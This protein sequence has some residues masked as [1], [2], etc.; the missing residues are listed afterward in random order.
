M[1]GVPSYF[2]KVRSRASERWDLLE[3]DP[4][5]A[6]PWHQLFMQVQSPRHVVSELLQ[7]ADD[8][9]ATKASVG[10]NGNDFIF[11][12]NGE[13]FTEEHFASLCRFGYSNKR[14]LHT[15]GFRGVGFKSTFSIGDIISLK[16][17]SLSVKFYRERFTEPVWQN[18][19]E[20]LENNTK[21]RVAI[22]DKLRLRELEKNLEDWTN[23]PA[24]LL[25]F[26]SIRSLSIH[27]KEIQ[28][29][30]ESEGPIPDS[31][32]M[33]LST[34]PDQK[35]LMIQSKPEAFPGDALAEI[36]QERM[37]AIDEE[38]PFPPC[39]ID[40]VL[41]YEG[42]LFVILPTG[43]K[44]DLPFAINAPFIQDPA[45]LKIKDPEIS[46]T[47]RWLLERA[48]TLSSKVMLEWLN[49]TD[50]DVKNRCDAYALLPDLIS[51]DRSIEDGCG[52]I[53][54]DACKNSLMKQ[55]YLLTEKGT[56][57]RGSCC[58]AIPRDLFDIWSPDQL[59][60][61][62]SENGLNLLARYI[63]PKHRCKLINW[64]CCDEIDKEFVLDSLCLKQLPKP[65]TWAQLLRL[66]G[67]V[68]DDIT[69]YRYYRNRNR[70]HIL[71]VHGKDVLFS[72]AEV[73]RLGEK[74]LLQSKE[75]WQF[76]S[77]YLLVLN[78]NW[79]R[80]L[81]E[82]RRR[83]E[84]ETI[85][86]LE[87]QVKASYKILE[88]LNLDQSS[89][90]SHVINQVTD[91]FFQK[92]NCDFKSCIRLAQLAA[93]LGASVSEKF[94]FITQDGN[95]KP[96]SEI[97]VY[98][99][100]NDLDLFVPI[101]WYNEH[102]LHKDYSDPLSCTKDEWW[103][104]VKS[105]RSRL[106]SFVPLI[107]TERRV[108]WRNRIFEFLQERGFNGEP[109]FPYSR[110]NFTIQDWDFDKDLWQVWQLS[111][112]N[113]TEI[114]G[115]LFTRILAQSKEYWAKSLY[116]K[117]FQN[118]KKY[119]Q[120]VTNEKLPASWIIKFRALPC[121]KDTRGYYH[122]PADL[123]LRTPDTESLLDVEPFVRAEDDNE[124]TRPLIIEVGVRDTP[125][126][127]DRLID[128]IRA[129]AISENPPIYEVEKWCSRLDH[130]SNQCNTDEFQQIKDAFT[131]HK[132]ILTAD[133]EWALPLEVF[134]IANEDDAPGAAVVHPRIQNLSLWHKI[135]VAELPTAE[136]SLKWLANIESKKKL[137]KDELR[138]V[139]TL[140]PRYADRVWLE[141]KHWLNLEGEWVPVDQL[142]YKLTM[143]TLTP[144]GNLFQHV[145][146]RTADLQK[147]NADRCRQYPFVG[148]PT[149]AD[150]IE[151]R[152]EN[153]IVNSKKSLPKPW[154]SALG[155]GFTRIVE[156]DE[157]ESSQICELGHRLA[158]TKWYF[159]DTLE[160]TPFINGTPSGTP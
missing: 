2:E 143:Q 136:L 100:Q 110:D 91:S 139:R 116:A 101:Q 1:T 159:V 31:N 125:T 36:K 26:R 119:K 107:Q 97:I 130:I 34:N 151:E 21:I 121:L 76:L 47:N 99:V 123:L 89:D 22:H 42:R 28:W 71:P 62:F 8:A 155:Q 73:I 112:Q 154:L 3:K 15:I 7:N 25:F 118:G 14:A 20:S 49:R 102:V 67:Y 144:W 56:I 115:R 117:V 57:E 82:Q 60:C 111:A 70:M 29:E 40:I 93:T 50:W 129:L 5:L 94:K 39:K 74:K 81:A 105:G 4:E 45:R 87:W 38:A 124:Q 61:L 134:L 35:Y 24:S 80:Y 72:A 95:L 127:P 23:S 66:W 131:Q 65:E 132:L 122:Q 30:I 90:V 11:V 51:K 137:S 17:P 37:V 13:D 88:T 69:G 16:T 44:T 78:Q 120:P 32:W 141:C 83:T 48:G 126:G 158:D 52:Q 86:E 53:V 104:W 54:E 108:Y 92:S 41:G 103:Q 113:N 152:L 6:G 106:Q 142:A 128:R 68:A 43:V 149:L 59:K 114:W 147:L 79:P 27:G 58:I 10:I 18:H 9:G 96:V 85:R 140:L 19:N 33:V 150:S 12:H 156:E 157:I 148:L 138:R 63:K 64:S 75:D 145:K 160:A 46:P 133:S 55:S 109:T 146:Q 135:G 153:G 84:Q 77:D 98:D